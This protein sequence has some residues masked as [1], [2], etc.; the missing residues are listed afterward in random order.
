MDK[1]KV[2]VLSVVLLCLV[3]FS[4]HALSYIS[5]KPT[6]FDSTLFL[7]SAQGML[8]GEKLYQNVAVRPDDWPNDLGWVSKPPVV[9]FLNAAALWVGRNGIESVRTMERAF[10]AIGAILIFACLLSLRFTHPYS[11]FGALVYA[12]TIS[13]PLVLEGGNLTE[14][15]GIVFLLG[16]ILCVAQSKRCAHSL[17]PHYAIGF[18]GLATLAVFTKEPFLLS[19]IPWACYLLLPWRNASAFVWV[20]CG[21]ILTTTLIFGLLLAFGSVSGFVDN[22]LLAGIDYVAITRSKAAWTEHLFLSLRNP[23]RKL[24]E[25]RLV[26]AVFFFCGVVSC[27]SANWLRRQQWLPMIVLLA[28]CADLVGTMVGGKYYG[29]YYMQA[30][31]SYSLLSACGFSWLG[32][33]LKRS[34]GGL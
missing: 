16:S 18:G 22:E 4:W 9:F 20:V 15:Y 13:H 8:Q 19:V 25:P 34:G 28:F 32:D 33:S 7:S 29:H 27:L 23:Y 10:A 1:I 3:A 26:T 30:A 24:F 2:A 21:A 11:F 5:G 12:T 31:G 17:K 14:E 6:L